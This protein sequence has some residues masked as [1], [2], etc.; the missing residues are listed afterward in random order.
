MCFVGC[1]LNISSVELLPNFKWRLD[2]HLQFRDRNYKLYIAYID[3]RQASLHTIKQN[4][5]ILSWWSLPA[6]SFR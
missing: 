4:Q 6:I 2:L 1:S 3:V 5:I